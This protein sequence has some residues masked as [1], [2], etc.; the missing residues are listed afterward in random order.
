[1]SKLIKD[2]EALCATKKELRAKGIEILRGMSK[3]DLNKLGF[4]ASGKLSWKAHNYP[5]DISEQR[6]VDLLKKKAEL[7]L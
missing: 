7:G 4:Y 5:G 2:L 6:M 3:T 1:M